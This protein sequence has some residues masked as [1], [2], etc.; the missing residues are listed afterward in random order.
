MS[1]TDDLA[2]LRSVA[3]AGQQA[4]SLSGRFFLW[5]GGLAAPAL[6]AHWALVSG[7]TGLNTA[8]VG[9]VW[10]AYGLIGMAGS[11]VLGRSL[12]NKPGSGAVNNRGEGAVWNGVMWMIAAYAIGIV[13]AAFAG[14]AEMILFDTI[15]LVAFGGYGVSFWVASSLGGPK[16]MRPLSIISWLATGGGMLLV[17]TPGLYLYCTA[18]VVILAVLPG[19]T[20]VRNEPKTSQA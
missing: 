7:L 19:L 17:G 15:P 10:L 20:L 12:R 8:Y 5:W 18:A 1:H 9:F 2:Y 3:E 16:W 4:A 11:V 13:I 14:R 6:L